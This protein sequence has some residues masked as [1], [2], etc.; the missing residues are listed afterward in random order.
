MDIYRPLFWH[1]GLFLQPQHFQ[2]SDLH[3]RSLLA[4]FL[5]FGLPHFWGVGE[6][7][8]QKMALENRTFNP[9]RGEFIFPD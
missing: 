8:I 1:Q 5:E 6:T 2:L 3:A 7:E 4:P 9:L